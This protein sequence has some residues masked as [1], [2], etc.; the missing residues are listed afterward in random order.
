MDRTSEH[1]DKEVKPTLASVLASMP[2]RL[3][4]ATGLFLVEN[5][6]D[7]QEP[8]FIGALMLEGNEDFPD[9]VGL[10]DVIDIRRLSGQLW[11]L[12]NHLIQTR[13]DTEIAEQEVKN[14]KKRGHKK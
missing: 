2:I 8:R 4:N 14:K 3:A 1:I 12:A 6:V 13:I 9:L 7:R 10:M 5:D 11:E